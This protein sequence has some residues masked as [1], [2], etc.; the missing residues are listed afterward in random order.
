MISLE[1][2]KFLWLDITAENDEEALKIAEKHFETADIQGFDLAEHR[3]V[4][5]KNNPNWSGYK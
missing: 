2:K 4:I 1:V 3:Q 5:A